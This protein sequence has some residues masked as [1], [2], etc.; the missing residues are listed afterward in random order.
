MLPAAALGYKA[1][2]RQDAVYLVLRHM[3]SAMRKSGIA[4][5]V[6]FSSIGISAGTAPGQEKVNVRVVKYDGLAETVRQLK[7]K[8][9]VVDFWAHW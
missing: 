3:E 5:C 7:G 4:L 1:E 6:I 9:V 8:V 2:Y